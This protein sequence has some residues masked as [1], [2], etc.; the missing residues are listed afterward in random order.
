MMNIRYARIVLCGLVAGV[1][2]NLL[3]AVMLA[4][5]GGGLLEALQRAPVYPRSGGAIF[6]AVDLAMGVWTVW[7]YAAIRPGDNR[8]ARTV[9]IVGFAWWLI[10]SLESAKWV[11]SGFIPTGV[12][13]APLA[14]TLPAMMLATAAGAWLYQRTEA[15]ILRP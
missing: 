11:A 13:L 12:V 5:V 15:P 4:L 9:A 14:A 6:F 10:K 2:W 3:A 7:L 8:S 1:V